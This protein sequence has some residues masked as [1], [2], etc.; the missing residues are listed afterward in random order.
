MTAQ[1][2]SVVSIAPLERVDVRLRPAKMA[3]TASRE[4]MGEIDEP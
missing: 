1:V 4:E 3:V 2:D